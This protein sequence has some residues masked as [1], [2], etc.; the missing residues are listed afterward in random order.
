[1]PNQQ[2]Q[3]VVVIRADEEADSA[4]PPSTSALAVQRVCGVPL[5]RR[6]ILTTRALGWRR[7]VVLVSPDT[8]EAVV[9]AVGEPSAL[10]VDLR[11][12]TMAPGA[13]AALQ[14]LAAQAD[15]FL[16]LEGHYVVEGALLEALTD[17]M[18]DAWLCDS[19]PEVGGSRGAEHDCGGVTS[20][21][22]EVTGPTLVYAGAALLSRTKLKAWADR[23]PSVGPRGGDGRVGM[24]AVDV[25]SEDRYAPELRRAAEALWCEVETAADAE[26]CKRA[27]V[28]GAQKH[29]LDL[30]AWYVN[31]PLEAA[32]TR[33]LADTPITPNQVTALTSALAYV[34]TG[35]FLARAWLPASLLALVVNVLD[36]VD[37]KLARVK[38]MSSRLGQLEHSLDQLYEQSWYAA[39]AWGSYRQLGDTRVLG[40]GVAM[41]LC[42]GFARHV[43]MQFRQVTGVPLG[44]YSPADRAFRRVDGRRNIYSLHMLLAV[45]IG[46]PHYAVCT[47]ALHAL[48]TG[49][50]Y[51]IRA[52]TH[53]RQLDLGRSG[54]T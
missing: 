14:Q 22:N 17:T 46:R 23:P 48:L 49:V 16:L 26:R 28:R 43:S 10:G 32:L 15:W 18:T 31:R 2:V 41:L 12:I 29:T 11:F 50:V 47:M 30:V 38:A 35:L 42:D 5:V 8:R 51:F 9:R 3:P 6:H 25:R 24:K 34:V 44:D 45:L 37:G 40:V 53:L 27:L 1:M 21:G 13:F 4:N 7:V 20:C 52:A 36:G 33:S 39:F 54:R 19:Q